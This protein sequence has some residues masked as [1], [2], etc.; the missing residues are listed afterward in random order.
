MQSL[1]KASVLRY[2]WS[3][4]NSLVLAVGYNVFIEACA[5]KINEFRMKGVT[6][7][8]VSDSPEG[9]NRYDDRALW[10][11]NLW[12]KLSGTTPRFYDVTCMNNEVNVK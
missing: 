12:R 3:I 8:V 6:M 7:V 4:I 5:N 10:V 1:Y 2:F 11:V 9:I